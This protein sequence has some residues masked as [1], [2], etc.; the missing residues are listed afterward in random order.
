MR[1]WA[2]CTRRRLACGRLGAFP[3]LCFAQGFDVGPEVRERGT[4][5]LLAG[6]EMSVQNLL[7]GGEAVVEMQ[8]LDLE[9]EPALDV[10]EGQV[11]GCGVPRLDDVEDVRVGVRVEEGE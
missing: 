7:A 8:G 6:S 10:F 9:C 5:F 1:G 4:Y 11:P 3:L 2:A